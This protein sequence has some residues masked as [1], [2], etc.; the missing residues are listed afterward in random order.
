M[1]VILAGVAGSGKSTVGTILASRLGWTYE[2]S[3]LLHSAADVAKMMS[4]VPLT[5]ADRWP[6]LNTVATWMDQRI[7]AGVSVVLACS[8]LKRSYRDYL[9]RGRPS[10]EIVML[11]VD[12]ATLMARLA[13]RH[14]HFFPAKLLQSQLADLEMP[15]PAEHVLVVPPVGS[16]ADMAGKI[17]EGLGLSPHPADPP[18]GPLPWDDPGRETA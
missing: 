2:D 6:W 3:D 17:I 5:D 18:P 15:A 16:P 1:I 14:V 9:R 12:Q 4:G 8:A 7:A 10:V 13:G 11:E